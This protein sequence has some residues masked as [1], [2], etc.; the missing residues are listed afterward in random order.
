MKT[1]WKKPEKTISRSFLTWLTLIVLVGFIASTGFTWM[2]Q[3]RLSNQNAEE[4][5]LY[6]GDHHYCGLH[7]HRCDYYRHLRLSCR[8]CDCYRHLC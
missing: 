2:L 5:L 8:R 3:T 6:I 7:C 4:L 1:G